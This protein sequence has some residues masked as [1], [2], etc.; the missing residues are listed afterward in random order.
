MP[1]TWSNYKKLSTEIRK[2]VLKMMFNSQTSHIGS[3]FSIV[4]LLVVLYFKVL[5]IDPKNPWSKDRDRL[6][7]SKGHAAAGLYA[8]LALRGFFSERLLDTY[9][10]NGGVLPGHSTM[11]C[12]PG[13]EVSTGSLG[14]GLS[15]GA[16]MALAAKYDNDKYR[17]F[18]L[19]SDGECEEGSV[20]ETAMFAA[21]NKLDNLVAIVDYNKLQALGRTEEIIG[22]EPLKDKWV[23]FGWSV[24]E[25]D[26]HDFS[27]IEKTLSKVPFV[28]NKPS[29]VIAHT[30]KGK[31]ISFMEDQVAWHYKSPNEEQ[32]KEGLQELESL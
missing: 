10:I 1:D 5:S 20:W 7:L 23:S 18:V 16:G 31:G 30:I 15:M 27:E 12:T 21:H 22:L 2:K 17:I 32:F 8:T 9:C 29:V 14:H 19:L 25:I 11:R 28:K 24:K 3:C 4:D 26:G 6:I 13:V